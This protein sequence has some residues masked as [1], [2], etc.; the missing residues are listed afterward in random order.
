MCLSV[1]HS[2]RLCQNGANEDYEIFTMDCNEDFSFKIRKA[3]PE[4]LNGSPLSRAL[5][6]KGY[7]KLA[8]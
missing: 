8:I 5:N 1:C 4:I 3:F 6:E 2:L 7:K